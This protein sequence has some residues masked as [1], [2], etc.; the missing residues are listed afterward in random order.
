MSN[1]TPK[2][3]NRCSKNDDKYWKAL[4][5]L[6]K[7]AVYGKAIENVG[8]KVDVKLESTSWS[9]HQNQ[10]ICYKKYFTMI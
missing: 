7:N 6:M 3:K 2:K 4:Y 8:K 10:A 9:W 5:K 1:S